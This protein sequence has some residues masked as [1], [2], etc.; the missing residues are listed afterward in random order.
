[1]CF[2][3]SRNSLH[4]SGSAGECD[5][6][7]SCAL[8]R[9]FSHGKTDRETNRRLEHTCHFFSCI[10]TVPPYKLTIEITYVMNLC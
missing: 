4:S 6:S 3:I 5:E 9:L 2:G 8:F 7:V 10:K 1:M